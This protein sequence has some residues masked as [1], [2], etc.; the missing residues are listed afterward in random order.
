MGFFDSVKASLSKYAEFSGRASRSEFWFFFLFVIG[1]QAMARLVDAIFLGRGGYLPGPV[2][3]I[4]ALVLLLPQIAVAVRRL[5]DVGKD[6]KELVAP[7]V[8]LFASSFVGYFAFVGF[9]GR[10]VAMGVAGITLL[11]FAR[12]VYLLAE[13]G[14]TVPNRYGAC[15]KRYRFKG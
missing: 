8:L 11:L 5:H 6:G 13:K 14:R 3:G 15:P 2:Y 1:A 4:V 12:L 10:I 7:L 9:I